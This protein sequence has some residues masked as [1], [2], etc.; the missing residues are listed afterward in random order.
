[1]MH[2]EEE[3][4]EAMGGTMKQWPECEKDELTIQIWVCDCE[5]PEKFPSL[6][7]HQN[8]SPCATLPD[9]QTGKTPIPV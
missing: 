4:E 1:M 7:L 3:E 6:T 8:L 5:I 9:R 2:S